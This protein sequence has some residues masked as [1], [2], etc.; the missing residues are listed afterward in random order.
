MILQ[1]PIF[2]PA[3]PALVD[4]TPADIPG[5]FGKLFSGIIGIMLFG[6]TIWVLFQLILGGIS[7]MSSGGD[8]GKMEEA[9]HRLTNAVTGLFIV[10]AS[11]S[12]YVIILNFLGLSPIGLDGRIELHLPSLFTEP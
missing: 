1:S 11:W 5:L 10:F 12:I 9:R 3:I 6:A 8:K 7:W 2:N 4:K